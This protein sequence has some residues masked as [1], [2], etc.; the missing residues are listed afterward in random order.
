[1]DGVLLAN[2]LEYFFQAST[3]ANVQD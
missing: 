1:M 2:L 3:Q